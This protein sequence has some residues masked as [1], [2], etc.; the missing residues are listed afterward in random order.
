VQTARGQIVA[1][2]QDL[3]P[4]RNRHVT[5]TCVSGDDGRTWQQG[6][7]IDLGGR[8][9]HDGAIEATVAELSGGRLLMLIRTNLDRFWEAYSDDGGRYWREMRPSRLDAS[10]APGYLIRLASGRLA[11]VWNRLYPEGKDSIARGDLPTMTET[12][13]SWQRE[14]LSLAFSMD[15]AKT[16]TKPVVIA[17]QPG[18]GLSYPFVFERRPGE[19]WIITR[20]PTKVS[21]SLKEA[22]FCKGP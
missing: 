19:L 5:L 13:A 16:W 7:I 3:A 22:D 12:K 2:M 4:S 8:G 6:N 20:Y 14:E 1:P 18:G 11:L 9:D 15:D 21:F 17:R 10:T